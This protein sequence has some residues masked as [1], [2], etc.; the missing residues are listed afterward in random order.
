[1]SRKLSK[2]LKDFWYCDSHHV[3]YESSEEGDKVNKL[4]G[5][6]KKDP[7][8][9][10]VVFNN[11]NYRYNRFRLVLFTKKNGDFNITI[12]MKNYGISKTNRI[13]NR[14]KKIASI[15]YKDGK[16]WDY[17][18]R[19]VRHL[20]YYSLTSFISLNLYLSFDDEIR[21]LND[22]IFELLT[23][24]FSWLRWLKEFHEET[25]EFEIITLNTVVKY[26]LYSKNKAL[27]HLY[28][29]PLPIAK[30]FLKFG[31]KPSYIK[32]YKDYIIKS[33]TANDEVLKS[34]YLK[35]T[36]RLSKILDKKVNLNWSVKRLKHEHDKYAKELNDI[37]FINDSE[38]LN[39]NIMFIKF[40]ESSGLELIK[41]TKDL[42]LEGIKQSHCVGS[43]NSTINSGAS[44]IYR[45]QNYTLELGFKI[46]DKTNGLYI[47]QFRA[48]NNTK[49]PTS[50][51]AS[52]VD[53]ITDFNSKLSEEDL[54]D[55][56]IQLEPTKP[57]VGHLNG[58]GEIFF[59]DLPF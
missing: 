52:V 15:T 46:D 50:V 11:N 6:Y 44:G 57:V 10:R 20:D 9:A 51:R 59:E 31:F 4:F 54:K 43:Y 36:L 18:P 34:E 26:K 47:K 24:R 32:M 22:K 42:A 38:P 27:K 23:E 28:Q 48:F 14:D 45:V 29:K 7:Y 5:L 40:E 39:N 37:V 58:V 1:M 16:F 53:L 17:N 41:T 35:D 55:I 21:A 19:R 30:K 49:P 8:I 12:I 25:R 56:Q 33:E 2:K 13:Y 3:L